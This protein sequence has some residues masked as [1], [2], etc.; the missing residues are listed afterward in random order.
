MYCGETAKDKED[1]KAFYL[2]AGGH[3]CYNWEFL[4]FH[5]CDSYSR[6]EPNLRRAHVS[7]FRQHALS[8]LYIMS[9]RPVS[10][11][12]KSRDETHEKDETLQIGNAVNIS[13]A[14]D[15]KS[16]DENK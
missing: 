3:N 7:A 12:Q 11:R 1:K 8:S 9:Y 6:Q 2:I 5:L 13:F 4:H 16:W 14:M 10:G 15:N